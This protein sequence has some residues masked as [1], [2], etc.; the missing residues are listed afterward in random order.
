[1]APTKGHCWRRGCSRGILGR[2]TVRTF[3]EIQL[4]NF[5]KYSKGEFARGES[6]ANLV[7]FLKMN[8]PLF[9]LQNNPY[10]KMEKMGLAKGNFRQN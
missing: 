4:N 10:Q 1:M 5:E 3:G 8:I 6:W 9:G 2:N 7:S